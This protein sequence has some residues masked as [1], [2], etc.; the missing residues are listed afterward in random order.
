[1]VE[2]ALVFP[3][4]KVLSP[5]NDNCDGF[6]T[7]LNLSNQ[8]LALVVRETQ[9][10]T[11]SFQ[12]CKQDVSCIDVVNRVPTITTQGQPQ[13]KGKSRL[14]SEQNK[15]CQRCVLCKSMS[16][17]PICSK[18]PTCCHRDQCWGKASDFVASL[19]KAGFKSQS[20]FSD[21]G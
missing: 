14:W 7:K 17:C 12:N 4:H 11:L 2:Q 5:T 13:R 8:R 18:C 1:M 3:S 20:G 10:Q 21:E 16:F 6:P 19:A 15:T 9:E